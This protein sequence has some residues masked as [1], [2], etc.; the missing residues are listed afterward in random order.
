MYAH[1]I[2]N[3]FNVVYPFSLWKSDIHVYFIQDTIATFIVFVFTL[4]GICNK[5]NL[6][7][8]ALS[9]GNTQSRVASSGRIQM[10][11]HIGLYNGLLYKKH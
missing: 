10:Q 5:Y 4:Y 11:T 1:F 9:I 7:Y 6:K 2:V 3:T 8:V